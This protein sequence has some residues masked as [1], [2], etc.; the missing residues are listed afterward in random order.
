MT[1][2]SVPI[3]TA[4][5]C[6]WYGMNKEVIYYLFIYQ[7]IVIYMLPMEWNIIDNIYTTY[8]IEYYCHK[9]L[10]PSLCNKIDASGNYYS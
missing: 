5:P 6:K 7:Y 2:L 3:F 4:V 8:I 10:N 9:K 1:V